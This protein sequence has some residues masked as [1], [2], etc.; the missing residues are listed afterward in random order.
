MPWGG[1]TVGTMLW[2][3]RHWAELLGCGTE[4]LGALG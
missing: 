4:A 1:G 3:W 2:Y